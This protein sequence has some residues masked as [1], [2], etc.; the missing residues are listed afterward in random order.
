MKSSKRGR[1]P[2]NNMERFDI[3]DLTSG[4]HNIDCGHDISLAWKRHEAPFIGIGIRRNQQI[5][6]RRKAERR[7]AKR[8]SGW[9]KRKSCVKSVANEHLIVGEGKPWQ[10]VKLGIQVLREWTVLVPGKKIHE[11]PPT[12]FVVLLI[13]GRGVLKLRATLLIARGSRRL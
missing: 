10:L 4:R 13:T 1:Y 2:R 5:K 3:C 11:V 9:I 12:K 8:F 7:G 6:Y